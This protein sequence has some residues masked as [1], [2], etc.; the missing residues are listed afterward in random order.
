MLLVDDV[1]LFPARGLIWL[2]KEIHQNAVEELEGE[3]ERI[4]NE[5]TDLY[6]MLETGQID[7]D[8]FDQQEA[9]L[10]DRL[11]S[12]E[13]Q[14]IG[15]EEDDDETDDDETD[16]DDDDSDDDE[17]DEEDEDRLFA[18]IDNDRGHTKPDTEHRGGARDLEVD[19]Q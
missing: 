12:L 2:F 5:L 7:E 10:L 15:G 19:H 17:E 18:L 13:E 1:L 9:A 6:M 3:A 16:D 4:R 14:G 8:E 11:D